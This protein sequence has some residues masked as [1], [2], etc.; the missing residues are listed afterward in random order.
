MVSHERNLVEVGRDVWLEVKSP[1]GM[2]FVGT[3][4][5]GGALAV[6]LRKAV[7]LLLLLFLLAI[8]WFSFMF[9]R[10]ELKG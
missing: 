4:E 5:I 1:L 10:E 7:L 3:K 2:N 6:A 8:Q 9:R